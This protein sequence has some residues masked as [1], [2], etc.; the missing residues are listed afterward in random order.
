MVK[1]ILVAAVMVSLCACR[2]PRGRLMDDTEDDL[3]GARSAGAATFDR[4][5]DRALTK[6]LT[7]NNGEIRTAQVK[8]AF[9]G[10]ENKSAEEL[11]DW[12]AQI[13]QVI[14]TIVENTNR[15]R[16]IARRFVEA[17]LR[18][19]RLRADDLYIPA[20][21]RRFTQ[22]LEQN[23]NPVD[24]L[25][26]AILTSGTTQGVELKQRDYILT[27]ELINV[28]TGDIDKESTRIRKEYQK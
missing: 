13:E 25:L 18:E 3:V 1:K 19:G 23:G 17:G 12:E 10:L 20:K 7:R 16:L 2:S 11:G 9:V 24:F 27:M 15:Y 26:Y 5:I 4:L 14:E 21:R 28:E 8:V 6:L 22:I